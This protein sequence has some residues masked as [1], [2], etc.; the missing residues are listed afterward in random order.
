MSILCH[1][2]CCQAF[3]GRVICN[4]FHTFVSIDPVEHFSAVFQPALLKDFEFMESNAKS[5]N[6]VQVIDARDPSR[7]QQFHI[8]GSISAPMTNILSFKTRCMKSKEEIKNVMKETGVDL[9]KDIISSCGSGVTAC[10]N[11]LAIYH[12][13]GETLPVY[14]GSITEWLDR[15]NE[16]IIGEKK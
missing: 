14:D 1:V 9:N 7:F 4:Y 6:P 16:D 11:A 5:K 2:V 15:A 13:T 10:V 8:L 12:A 3:Y